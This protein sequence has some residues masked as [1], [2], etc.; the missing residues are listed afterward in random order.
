MNPQAP[1]LVR[2]HVIQRE[3]ENFL[4]DMSELICG[5]RAIVAEQQPVQ[6]L[7]LA[8]WAV[9]AVAASLFDRADVFDQAKA[10]V[11]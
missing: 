3:G 6:H 5:Q 10:L 8:L 1:A 9:Q 7:R 4:E 11:Q 2:L